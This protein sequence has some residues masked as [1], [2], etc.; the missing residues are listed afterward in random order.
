VTFT[1]LARSLA[2][3]ESRALRGWAR[4]GR[5]PPPIAAIDYWGEGQRVTKHTNATT[6]R[7]AA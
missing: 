2:L 4:A 5:Q 6:R 1:D 3:Q 7:T